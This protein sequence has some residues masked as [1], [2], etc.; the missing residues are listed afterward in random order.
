MRAFVRLPLLVTILCA[1]LIA[2]TQ[3]QADGG[4]GA[5]PATRAFHYRVV[6]LGG[7]LPADSFFMHPTRQMR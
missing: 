6:P 4:V 7:D 3:A 5:A 2:P 1:A